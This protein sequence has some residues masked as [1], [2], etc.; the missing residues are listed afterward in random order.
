MVYS[1]T[2]PSGDV[3]NTFVTGERSPAADT[4]Y[5]VYPAL[6]PNP[7]TPGSVFKKYH[8][9]VVVAKPLKTRVGAAGYPTTPHTA[10]IYQNPLPQPLTPGN[11]LRA[12]LANTRV[13]P[14][15]AVTDAE[16][17]LEQLK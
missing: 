5:P 7:N 1:L 14:K 13:L 11:W 17:P 10:H 3:L 12:L 15:Q 9:W 6:G 2:P 8:R 4:A 16:T